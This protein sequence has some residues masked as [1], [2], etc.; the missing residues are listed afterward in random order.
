MVDI[1]LSRL[2]SSAPLL[3]VDKPSLCKM[4]EHIN[5]LELVFIGSAYIILNKYY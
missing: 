2:G 4:F 5:E 3:F 1:A